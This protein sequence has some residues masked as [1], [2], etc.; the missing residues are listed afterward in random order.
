MDQA[1][2]T[3]HDHRATYFRGLTNHV[4]CG[5][6]VAHRIGNAA[7]TSKWGGDAPP[8]PP[9]PTAKEAV[10]GHVMAPVPYDVPR[11][12]KDLPGIV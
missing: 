1:N 9:P 6:P 4:T 7:S 5:K 3:I 10:M 11:L 8:P 2:F 12:P